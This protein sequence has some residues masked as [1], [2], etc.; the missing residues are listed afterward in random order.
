MKI[1]MP[2]GTVL[3]VLLFAGCGDS[4]TDSAADAVTAT[5][6]QNGSTVT[7]AKD[8]ILSVILAGNPTTGYQ[9]TVVENNPALL[10][11]LE[12]VYEPDSDAIGSGGLY[13]FRFK[14]IQEGQGRLRMAYGRSWEAAPIQKFTLDVNVQADSVATLDGTRWALAAWSASSLDPAGFDVTADFARGQIG[15]RSAVNTYGGPFT[16]AADGTF[17]AGPLAM[18]EMA[19]EPAA[20]QAESLYHALLAQANRWRI[21][22]GQLVLSKSA[23][24]LLIFNPR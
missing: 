5:Q 14:A 7:L 4:S 22:G 15:G 21:A 9:W 19:G 18:T 23:H 20:M 8:A 13:T 3:A 11:P 10:Q 16:A 6:A 1:W 12:P 2:I 17:A 24:D